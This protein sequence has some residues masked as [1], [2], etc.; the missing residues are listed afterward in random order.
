MK[1]QL[2][3]DSDGDTHWSDHEFNQKSRDLLGDKEKKSDDCDGFIHEEKKSDERERF[4]HI[5][6]LADSLNRVES[7]CS[8]EIVSDALDRTPKKRRR[9]DVDSMKDLMKVLELSF[10]DS[11]QSCDERHDTA[12]RASNPPQ[13]PPKANN[14]TDE[15][16]NKSTGETAKLQEILQTKFGWNHPTSDTKRTA[17]PSIGLEDKMNLLPGH[18]KSLMVNLHRIQCVRSK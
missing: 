9:V 11:L 3:D 7:A 5:P 10:E 4:I 12:N 2:E 18:L 14:C 1:F 13:D 6:Q 8:F 17:T 16:A 15:K